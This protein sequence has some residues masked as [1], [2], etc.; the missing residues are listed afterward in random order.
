MGGPLVPGTLVLAS[1]YCPLSAV[2]SPS[3]ETTAKPGALSDKRRLIDYFRSF[4]TE[5]RWERMIQ[6][7]SGRTRYITIVLEDLYQ[8]HNASAV[9]RSCDAFGIQDVHVIENRNHFSINTGIELGTSKW[10]DIYRYK[11]K[12]GESMDRDN[13][14]AA[15]S[16]LRAA[17]YRI[18]ATTP[19]ADDVDLES[20][21]L[22][23]GKFA[24]LFGNELQGL[25]EKALSL[26]D[27]YMKIPMYGF[28]ESLNISVSCAVALHHLSW[29]LR[30][31]VNWSLGEGESEEVL[32]SWLRRSVKN[33]KDLEEHYSKKHEST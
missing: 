14:E 10:L 21:D 9:L 7:L 22:K 6:V 4:L 13:T 20:F 19:H 5:E 33:A 3:M 24:L 27:E 8:P 31:E 28:V 15:L 18:I 2:V 30:E 17:G 29:K 1:C 25:S 11:E 12:P 26:A 23:K 32:L 16:A